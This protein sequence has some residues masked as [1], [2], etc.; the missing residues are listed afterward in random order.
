[1]SV[2]F[3]K[4][5]DVFQA[6]VEGHAPD[7]WDAYLDRACAGDEELRRN[8]ALLLRAHAEREGP[9]DRGAFGGG[10]TA[11]DESEAEPLEREVGPYRL[12]QQLGEGGMGAVW[13][14]QQTEPVK[15]LVALK[16]I[17]PG[18][19]SRQVIARFEQER[20]ALALMDHPNIAKV[21]DAG[22]TA[23]GR[24]YFVMELVKGMPI[25]RYCD[26]QRLT[27]RQRLG[28][29][30]DVCRAVQHAH[31]KGV[32]HRDLKPSN[33]LVA[34][35]DGK[36]VPKVI[37][38]G[39]A[40]AAGQQL[41]EQ[42]LVT[43]FG[44]VVGTL[45]YMSPE[46]AEL[47]QL[48]I[49][50]RS[51]IYSLG[52]LLYELLTGSPPLDRK[53]LREAALLEVLR[54]IREEEPPTPS[55]RL[56]TTDELPAV[57][58]KR[59]L[60]PRK[61]SGLL[62]G[63]LD[64][65]VMKAL[66]K[67]RNRR[68]ESASA[69]AADV[70]RYL[71]DEPVQAGPASAWYRLRKFA[72]RNKAALAM[73]AC[74]FLA[75]GGV[76]AAV[77]WAVR[78]RAARD[79]DQQVREA[80]LDGEVNRALDETGPL[81]EQHKWAEALAAVGRAEKLLAA[82]GRR[83][84]PARLT[85]LRR[86]LTT[87]ER[88]E[89]IYRE[90]QIGPNYQA[91][92]GFVEGQ[93]Y[94]GREQELSLAKEFRDAGIDIQTLTAEEAATRVRANRVRPALVQALDEWAMMRRRDRGENDPSW[95]KLIAIAQLADPDEWRDRFREALV[96]R[97]RRALEE[98]ADTVPVRSV[99][100]ATVYLLGTALKELGALDKAMAV[101]R[102][103]A[104]QYCDDW[105]LH[106]LLGSYYLMA[107]RPPRY[108]DALRHCLVASAL[109]PRWPRGHWVVAYVLLGK[110][111]VEEAIAES[112]RA[113]ELSPQDPETWNRRGVAYHRT[114]QWEKA[115]A[116]YSRA[117]E[118]DPG[119]A[120]AWCNRGDVHDRLG[121]PREAVG[122]LSRA[123][124][125][126]PSFDL[127]W[128][129]L[130]VA[131]GHLGE[132]EKALAA[133]G[134]CLELNPR[135]AKG[136]LNRGYV[137][138]VFLHEPERAVPGYARAIEID[139]GY[140]P[141]WSCRA[142]ARMDLGQWD[143]AAADCALWA[144]KHPD[145]HRAWLQ[146]AALCL[147]RGDAAGYRECCR[148]MLTRFGDATR[149]DVAARTARTCALAPRAVNDF[150]PVVRLSDVA[151][152]KQGSDR[153]APLTKGLVEFRAGRA[154]EAVTWLR[155]VGAKTGGDSLDATAFAVTALAELRLHHAEQAR[156]ALASAQTILKEK[157]PDPAKRRS[158]AGDWHD[159]LHAEILCREVEVEL[160]KS[161]R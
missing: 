103:G 15:R 97:D 122:D 126:D 4:L 152:G 99:S 137:Y 136:W 77:G 7:Q 44:A 160:E 3:E 18:M 13:M 102:D 144:E 26:E 69:L 95:K 67:D 33:V 148:E 143:Q 90:P 98:L 58:A 45:E 19:D 32:I 105:W 153:W 5:R 118:L 64:W 40:K 131:Y 85:E 154:G 16:V 119:F 41:T 101:L 141:P 108:D 145:E 60:E 87:A 78:D 139:P 48:D 120:R 157:A 53:R 161:A 23:T 25:T 133:F 62:R 112:S 55:A 71:N 96:R 124:E 125:I 61:L 9:L 74:A 135:S 115:L 30:V 28:L 127:S 72:R 159:W 110:E 93:S 86:D 150:G 89:R 129:A 52:V 2:N 146:R 39:V 76:A 68:Y 80:A 31:Q 91:T 75:L 66:E 138:Q 37:D 51:D 65:I 38:F 20:Q 134:K 107:F 81:I 149:A 35:Y 1:M 24:P 84:W 21:L 100:P 123:I 113:I 57:A 151:L 142:A 63:E 54:L 11:A 49:D 130:G 42:T 92:Q 158:F 10:R 104:R 109:R 132:Y 6:A 94:L 128:N 140:W 79:H 36:P 156:A 111:A 155:R 147:H 34:A 47:N 29:F 50:T 117:I 114:G 83:E 8:A 70:Q 106:D 121:E 14:A 116:D 12:I 27:P 82:A 88:L 59:G 46:Q 17:K 22:T 56:S 73:A 43:G